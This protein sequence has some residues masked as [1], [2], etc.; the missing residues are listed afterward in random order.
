MINETKKETKITNKVT[1][2]G[3]LITSGR[4][5]YGNY[6]ITLTIMNL[7]RKQKKEN[8]NDHNKNFL[9]VRFALDSA[10]PASIRIGSIVDVEGYVQAFNYID[11]ALQ[12]RKYVQRFV[13]TK[14]TP[15][16]TEMEEVFGVEGMFYT[17]QKIKVYLSGNYGG[18]T[19]DEARWQKLKIRTP[20]ISKRDKPNDVQISDYKMSRHTP[21]SQF[22]IGEKVACI[23]T[24]FTPSKEIRGEIR[25]YEDLIL[26]DIVSLEDYEKEQEVM[27]REL[28]QFENVGKPESID[29]FL[30]E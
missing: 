12:K 5:A 28:L 30:S 27:E 14:I 3:K 4:N 6:E 16:K 2:R 8:E 22:E 9:Y 15:V 24:V 1:A 25:Y 18:L 17:D 11:P 29:D 20:Q 19:I 23:C 13:A 10:L 21:L 26:N 7:S